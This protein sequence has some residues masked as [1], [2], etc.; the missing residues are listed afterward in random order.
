MSN[1]KK[2][3]RNAFKELLKGKTRALFSVHTSRTGVMW[4]EDLPAINIWSSGEELEVA[5]EAPWR[6][7]RACDITVE[8]YL[9][10]ARN[11]DDEIDDFITE[12]E[13][14]VDGQDLFSLSDSVNKIIYTSNNVEMDGDHTKQGAVATLKYSV[15]YFTYAGADAEKLGDLEGIDA[16]WDNVEFTKDTIDLPTT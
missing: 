2:E 3:I 15:E 12:V 14:L 13:D 16:R 5:G 9:Q 4:E 7:K 8:L 11:V 1:K 6:Y 10:S